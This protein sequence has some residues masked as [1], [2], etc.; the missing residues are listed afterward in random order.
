MAI[1]VKM[2]NQILC[3]YPEGKLKELHMH[4]KWSCIWQQTFWPIPIPS[5]NVCTVSLNEYSA[6][7][8]GD[9]IALAVGASEDEV[10]LIAYFCS[11]FFFS[12][13]RFTKNTFA[14]EAIRLN[15]NREQFLVSVCKWREQTLI[16]HM[17]TTCSLISDNRRVP[18]LFGS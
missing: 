8:T 5:V 18:H 16:I 14:N 6:Q 1:T 4:E 13:P 2:S 17:L 11:V 15:L 7:F 9:A 10:M 3:V 12:C